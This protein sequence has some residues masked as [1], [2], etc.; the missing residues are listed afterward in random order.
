[1]RKSENIFGLFGLLALMLMLYIIFGIYFGNRSALIQDKIIDQKAT[2]EYNSQTKHLLKH[3]NDQKYLCYHC[4][5]NISSYDNL[6]KL[7]DNLN[8]Q[9][10]IEEGR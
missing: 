10:H 9:E 3:I 1:L 4:L 8:Q 6:Q 5:T 2:K 7:I